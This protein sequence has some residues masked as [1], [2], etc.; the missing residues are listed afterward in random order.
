M[1]RAGDLGGVLEEGSISRHVLRNHDG[2]TLSW[3]PLDLLR[4]G[5]CRH[6]LWLWWPLSMLET[7]SGLQAF[8]PLWWG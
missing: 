6:L 2:V 1:P 5:T 4:S 7:L 8:R 3:V